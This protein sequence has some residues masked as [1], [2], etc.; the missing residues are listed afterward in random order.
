MSSVFTLQRFRISKVLYMVLRFFRSCCIVLA[1]LN[2]NADNTLPWHL[3]SSEKTKPNAPAAINTGE[4]G[5]GSN[6]IVVALIDSGVISSHPSLDGRLLP[7]YDMLSGPN[8]LRGGR[9][10][11]Y[12]PDPRNSK[13]M[14]NKSSIP[15]RTHGTEVASLI[16]GNGHDGVWG[17]NPS[18]LIL[19]IRLFGSCPISRSDLLDS[20]AWAAGLSVQN[21]PKNIN[22]ARVINLS[23]SGG[24]SVCG[25][26]LQTL[27]DSVSEKKIFV[28]AAAGNTFGKA[29]VEPANCKGVI[30]VGAVNAEN[31]VEKY[32]ALDPR[33]TIYAPGGGASA[34]GSRPWDINKLRVATFDTNFWGDEFPTAAHK[35]VGTSYAAPLVAGFISLLI[36]QN[37]EITPSE[38]LS[39]I[40]RFSRPIETPEACPVCR[41]RSL[42][43]QSLN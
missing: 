34:V 35:G 43:L 19:P 21:T 22:P 12:S 31:R 24:R 5:L 15:F 2:A 13:C 25:S 36:S 1:L 28:V 17:I 26:D 16:A 29:L 8:N 7:G 14:N 42:N 11:D 3:G 27:L 20:I 38:F 32:S 41:P 40:Q 23:F 18:A 4:L 37:K 9:S 39:Q 33:T 6:Q 10:D 30:S